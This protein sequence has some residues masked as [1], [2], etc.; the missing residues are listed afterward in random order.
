MYLLLRVACCCRRKVRCLL[1][2]DLVANTKGQIRL[3]RRTTPSCNVLCRYGSAEIHN[4][5]KQAVPM[6]GIVWS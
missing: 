1:N 3:V 4:E 2:T 6:I 5:N